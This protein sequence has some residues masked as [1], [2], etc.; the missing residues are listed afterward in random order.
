MSKQHRRTGRDNPRKRAP[1]AGTSQEDVAGLLRRLEEA[2]ELIA[3]IR[4]GSVDAFLVGQDAQERV[5]TLETADRPYRSFV[6]SMQQGAVTLDVDGTILFCNPFG[7]ALLRLSSSEVAGR[8]FREFV[9]QDDRPT[10]DTLLSRARQETATGEVSLAR[11][12]GSVVPVL[13]VMNPLVLDQMAA[14]S[15]LVTDLTERRHHEAVWLAQNQLRES[16]EKFRTLAEALPQIIWTADTNGTLDYVNE[17]WTQYSGLT[18]A[19]TLGA[20]GIG[21]E[22]PEDAPAARARWAE[23]VRTNSPFEAQIRF[24]RASDG[25]YRWFLCRGIP[26]RDTTGRVVR[27]FGASTDIDDELQAMRRKDEFVAT[28]AHELR[29]PLAPMRNAVQVLNLSGQLAP[30]LC[31]ARDIIGRQVTQMT[32]LI[33][34]LLDVSRISLNR[35]QLRRERVELAAVVA[36]AIETVRPRAETSGLDLSIELPPAPIHVD[37]D[38]I[39]LAQVFANLLDNACKYT[40]RGGRV[41][42][43]VELNE[44]EVVVRVRDTGIGIASDFLPHL[45]DKFS[46]AVPALERA[47][48]GLGIGLA[49]VQ[50]LLGL[51]GGTVTAH[52]EG[53]G[54]GSEFVVRLPVP[55][56]ASPAARW[57]SPVESP[58]PVPK[59]RI[60]VVDDN[61]DSTASL[62]MLLQ[63]QGHEVTM[64]YDG[65]QA[66]ELCEKVRPDVVLLDIGMPRLNGY[67]AC[68]RIRAQPWGRDIVVIAQTGWGQEEDRARTAAAGFDA[69]L[70]KPIEPASLYSL[71]TMPRGT[72]QRA[73]LTNLGLDAAGP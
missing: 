71:I 51:H 62:S 7:L 15:V 13:V 68:R 9:A 28:L 53:P 31:T 1:T 38:P 10:L 65:L 48:G 35:L 32:R 59:R 19:Q 21:F 43:D 22:H 49:L 69:H 12:D 66:V 72:G 46:Q 3:A 5:Y 8:H 45:F 57:E 64:A 17:R 54:R 40:E 56:P 44:G 58:A 4:S 34:D 67:D 33:D 52:S 61:R 36:Q 73:P 2:E 39:R 20:D 60:L 6:E 70:T 23:A 50:G 37:A 47:Q 41:A 16:E 24:R 55:A 25:D 30:E 26:M 29:N 14:I 42:L 11:S 18:L 63:L 27:W